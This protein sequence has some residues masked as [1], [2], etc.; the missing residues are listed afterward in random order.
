[1][2]K[3]ELERVETAQQ[4]LK[5]ETQLHPNPNLTPQGQ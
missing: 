2:S 3:L 4:V 5:V 1:M